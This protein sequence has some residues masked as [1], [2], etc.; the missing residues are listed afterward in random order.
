MATVFQDLRSSRE[1]ELAERF[2]IQVVCEWIGNSPT[3]ASRHYLQVTD[4]HFRRATAA[5]DVQTA[6]DAAEA[7]QN[8]AQYAHK[9]VVCPL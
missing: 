5:G 7:A 4:E 9:L 3:V 1:T 2:P 8:P 6:H